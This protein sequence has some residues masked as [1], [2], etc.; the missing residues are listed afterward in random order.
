MDD[1]RVEVS[2]KIDACRKGWR[3]VWDA[4]VAAWNKDNRPCV[5]ESVTFSLYVKTE[6]DPSQLG[7]QVKQGDKPLYM[8][9]AGVY[10]LG[11]F[12]FGT[13]YTGV[14]TSINDDGSSTTEFIPPLTFKNRED[15]LPTFVT[16]YHPDES[17]SFKRTD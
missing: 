15:T 14:K 1:Y 17:H 3:G 4:I 12:D 11:E 7:F 6:Q 8:Y 9:S 10:S 5:Q 16:E 13:M 2:T